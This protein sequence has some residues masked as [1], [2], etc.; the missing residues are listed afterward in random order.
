MNLTSG[1]CNA[2]QHF[3]RDP[4]YKD[5]AE[6]K[7]GAKVH[8]DP[9][10]CTF[11]GNPQ[12]GKVG[13]AKGR[14][15]HVGMGH[16]DMPSGG[17]PLP[18]L[19]LTGLT[20]L[21]L[22]VSELTGSIPS[23]I[24]QL[25]ELTFLG[26][27]GNELTGS[28]PSI[29]GELTTLARLSLNSNQLTGSMPS[30][31]A[32]LTALTSLNLGDNRLTGTVPQEMLQLEK[33]TFI[34]L[35]N[36]P[37]LTGKLP[38]FN[39]SQF[40]ECCSMEGDPF[41]CPLPTGANTTCAGGPSSHC[42]GSHAPP[43]CIPACSGT[44]S[45][46]TASDCSA[47]QQFTRDPLYK[48]WAEGKCGAQV[49]TDPC[50]CT[51]NGKVGCANGRITHLGMGHENMPSGSIPLALLDLTG[52]TYL[53][54]AVS[55]LTGSIPSAI[56]QLTGLTYLGLGSNQLTGSVPKELAQLKTLTFL[57]LDHNQLTGLLPAFSFSQFTQCCAM[58]GDPFTCPLPA[59]AEKCAGSSHVGGCGR[60][61]APTCKSALAR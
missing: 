59:G 48:E 15:T 20:F 27:G 7:C 21:Y 56:G 45:T 32:K 13:C 29:L 35:Q 39:F 6:G 28:I 36:N 3:T 26:L 10:S 37:Q 55:E 34:R 42:V 53:Y 16:E 50:S 30:A 54:L 11:S 44:S 1:D 61:P 46:L 43:T 47:W 2:W 8:T 33:L 52:L 24:G 17:I 23:A 5:W 41:T 18:L 40:T 25:T 31:I 58:D 19:D 38:K 49:H 51:F 9:C 60:N 57:A 14:I 22:A 12:D 4:L